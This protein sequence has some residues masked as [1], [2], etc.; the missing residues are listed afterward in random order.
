MVRLL[1]P[2]FPGIGRTRDQIA[3]FRNQW[4]DNATAALDNDQP[5]VVV[6]GDSLSQGIGAESIRSSYAGLVAQDLRDTGARPFGIVN[7]SKSGARTNDVL[8][9]QLPALSAIDNQVLLGMCAVGNNDLLRSARV[10]AT[11]KRLSR[12]IEELP[13]T[14]AIATVPD[15][16]SQLA[17]VINR[18]IRSEAHRCGHPLADVGAA[19]TSWKGMM[20]SDGFHPNGAGHRLWADTFLETLTTAGLVS[21]DLRRV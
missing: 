10:G 15:A 8:D 14:I 11:K 6:L 19:L 17:K 2:V 20:A 1:G 13:E 18:H 12:L 7:L 9:V 3:N 16:R 21:N 4:T 5:V